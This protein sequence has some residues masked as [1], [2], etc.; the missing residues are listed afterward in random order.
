MESLHDADGI[1]EFNFANLLSSFRHGA[2]GVQKILTSQVF[3]RERTSGFDAVEAM[4][5]EEE[6]A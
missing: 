1:G 3:H 2:E 4:T 5:L 6:A